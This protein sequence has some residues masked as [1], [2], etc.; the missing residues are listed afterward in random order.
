[1][2]HAWRFTFALPFVIGACSSPDDEESDSSALSVSVDDATASTGSESATDTTTDT[3][4]ATDGGTAGE[5]AAC[6]PLNQDECASGLGCYWT[7]NMPQPVI[8]EF[9][10]Q[11]AGDLEAGDVCTTDP[12]CLPGLLCTGILPDCP[13]D[14]CCSPFCELGGAPCAGGLTC[15]ELFTNGFGPQGLNVGVCL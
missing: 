12:D 13:A 15:E 11:P 2:N 10:C 6:H 8:G 7:A 5:G 9:L 3:E 4:E 1:M 14:W